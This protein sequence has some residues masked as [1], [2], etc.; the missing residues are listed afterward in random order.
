MEDSNSK[1]KKKSE[2]VLWDK[3]LFPDAVAHIFLIFIIFLHWNCHYVIYILRLLDDRWYLLK[4]SRSTSLNSQL[5]GCFLDPRVPAA[6]TTTISR[7]MIFKQYGQEY[8]SMSRWKLP[9]LLHTHILQVVIFSSRTYTCWGC[10]S[11]PDA[12]RR[13]FFFSTP[14]PFP[15]MSFPDLQTLTRCTEFAEDSSIKLTL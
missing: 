7:S 13:S 3:M 2:P 4:T 5:S 10:S 12:F 8:K 15:L 6:T 14:P 1:D 11:R 9:V